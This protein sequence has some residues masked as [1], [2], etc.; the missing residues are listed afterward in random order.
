M[1]RAGG[2]TLRGALGGRALAAAAGGGNGGDAQGENQGQGGELL[3][4][5]SFGA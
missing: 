2:S 5:C 4:L 1:G 3:H